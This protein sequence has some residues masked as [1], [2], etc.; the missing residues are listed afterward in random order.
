MGFNFSNFV[1][2]IFEQDPERPIN[3]DKS[4][5]QGAWCHCAVGEYA[6][7]APQH[8]LSAIADALHR[9]DPALHGTLNKCEP[10]T[11][12]DLQDFISEQ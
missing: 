3:H 2:F 4:G 7:G 10:A 1:R 11:Y 12:G 9:A 8:D 6:P 5:E